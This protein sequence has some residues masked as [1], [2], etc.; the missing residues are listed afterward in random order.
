MD[1]RA[2]VRPTRHRLLIAMCIS[3]CSI[4]VLLAL[5][6]LLV[7][8]SVSISKSNIELGE[9]L[10]VHIKKVESEKNSEITI[11]DKAVRS[12]PRAEIDS[13]DFPDRQQDIALN[14]FPEL[15]IEPDSVPTHPQPTID[16]RA[17]A[18]EV[19]KASIDE[20]FRQEESRASN[21]RRTRSIM[22]QSVGDTVAK[23]T[24]PL[25][26]DIRFKQYSRV[27]GIGINIGSCF[28]GVPIVGVPVEKRSADINIFV[29]S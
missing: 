29:C 20:Y 1:S 12:L 19:A 7:D 4:A 28:I 24:E 2:A 8:L 22:F 13:A 25:F 23:D 17:T 21:W 27:L 9:G 15:T 26:S 14:D 10:T 6:D 16:W 11:D 18:D 3:A 5:F